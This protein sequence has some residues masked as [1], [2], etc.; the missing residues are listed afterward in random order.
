MKKQLILLAF[1]PLMVACA[2]KQPE[3]SCGCQ[4]SYSYANERAVG[5]IYAVDTYQT[6]YEPRTYK[7]STE[8]RIEYYPEYLNSTGK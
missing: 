2:S 5:M 4:P 7:V 6:I 1:A 8:E 3:S